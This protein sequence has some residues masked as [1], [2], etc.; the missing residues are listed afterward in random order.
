MSEGGGGSGGIVAIA[1][2]GFCFCTVV[3]LAAFFYFNDKGRDWFLKT[4][5]LGKYKDGKEGDEDTPP[6]DDTTD[7]TGDDGG[8]GGGGGGVDDYSDGGGTT[9]DAPAPAPAGPAGPAAPGPAA[10]TPSGACETSGTCPDKSGADGFCPLPYDDKAARYI[11]WDASGKVGK[12]CKTLKSAY[13]S[14][15]C[16]GGDYAPVKLNVKTNGNAHGK[17]ITQH[18]IDN[19]DI[20]RHT[21]NKDLRQFKPCPCDATMK[22]AVVT[23][24]TLKGAKGATRAMA[25]TCFGT[26]KNTKA[27]CKPAPC[28]AGS[29]IDPTGL[30]CGAG[31]KQPVKWVKA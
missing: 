24:Q 9:G 11:K 2:V 27:T 8:G 26:F 17:S 28:P 5:K 23:Y 19:K 3:G 30:W 10:P 18:L 13:K 25:A 31:K 7:Y 1:L 12:C 15:E 16:H 4:F 14:S 6:A 20:L 29:A 21:T 22:T